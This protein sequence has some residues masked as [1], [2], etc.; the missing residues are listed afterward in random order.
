VGSLLRRIS[1]GLVTLLC[2]GVLRWWVPRSGS[3]FLQVNSPETLRQQIGLSDD[4]R[5]EVVI[6]GGGPAGSAAAF[7]LASHGVKTC[8]IDRSAFPRDKLC[9]GLLT[10]RS[11]KI[12]ERVFHAQW[13]NVIDSECSGISFRYHGN[14]LTDVLDYS[15]LY[16]TKRCTFDD[17]LLQMA[18]R[19]GASLRLNRAAKTIDFQR[20]SVTLSD[21]S[22][23]FF[24]YLVGAD[25]IKS[26]VARSLFGSSFNPGTV[27]FGLELDVFRAN[28]PNFPDVP[29]IHIGAAR[30][31]YGWVFP[32]GDRA[33]LGVGGLHNKNANLAE[34]FQ[35][36]LRL[37][38]GQIPPGR[39]KGHFLPYGDFRPV[40]GANDVLLAGDAAGLA[41]SITGEGIAF[42]MQSGNA[43]ALSIIDR[44]LRNDARTALECY[45][46]RY[47]EMTH[48][49]NLSK[50]YRWLVFPPILERLFAN[51]LP[52]AGE[53]QHRYLDILADEIEYDCMPRLMAKQLYR[54]VRRALSNIDKRSISPGR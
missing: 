49:I 7:T 13:D 39:V 54:G 44:I 31:G 33:T 48:I 17:F 24:R 53:I 12:F 40:P 4:P 16:V 6:V 22:S 3:A 21:G 42:A 29:E 52:D 32:K 8:V 47:S 2:P 11:K 15:A 38:C 5:F 50:R 35:S 41:D 30:W 1:A 14:V 26:V 19:E 20:K 51:T 36:F 10:Q 34:R 25:G 18:S 28:V 23:I 9:G 27:G 43:A 46:P 37:R 45:L